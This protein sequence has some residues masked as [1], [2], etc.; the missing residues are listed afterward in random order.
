M[1][2]P[3]TWYL[4]NRT[5]ADLQ[6]VMEAIDAKMLTHNQDPSAHGQSSEAVYEHR[7]TYALDHPITSVYA[8]HIAHD[9]TFITQ[10]SKDDDQ[11][12][13]GDGV[14]Q[15]VSD[16]KKTVF[17]GKI[18]NV[19]LFATIYAS[20]ADA[21]AFARIRFKVVQSSGTIYYPTEYGYI[22]PVWYGVDSL[23]E[24]LQT[25]THIAS[26]PVG[27]FEVTI[28]A[29]RTSTD[30]EVKILGLQDDYRSTL[31]ILTVGSDITT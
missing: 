14:W 1:P 2:D 24:T 22:M 18:G 12:L 23:A 20:Y 19:M 31:S 21:G 6:T 4:L 16:L 25:F 9:L 26:L 29:A 5:V 28:Q 8:R 10:V 11:T 13:T 30:A 17:S 7:N 27:S 3:I 15:D